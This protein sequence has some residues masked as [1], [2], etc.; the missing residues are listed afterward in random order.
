MSCVFLW[1]W[2]LNIVPLTC[3]SALTPLLAA[4]VGKFH[5]LLLAGTYQE[6]FRLE[7]LS[8][9]SGKFWAASQPEPVPLHFF[10]LLRDCSRPS[11]STINA[12]HQS[13]FLQ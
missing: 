5:P 3:Q 4:D 8:F 2:D 11:S 12:C 6:E 9:H 10:I 1:F 13:L 7:V